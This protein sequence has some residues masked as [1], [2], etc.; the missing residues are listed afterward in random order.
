MQSKFQKISKFFLLLTFLTIIFLPA[1][2]FAQNKNSNT[3]ANSNT[4]SVNTNSSTTNAPTISGITTLPP[5]RFADT[6]ALVRGIINWL[7]GLTAAF[8][9]F[10][11]AY[12]GIMYMTAGG[13]VAKA[14]A[15]RKNLIWAI[16]GIIIIVLSFA[17]INWV[18]AIF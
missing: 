15:A 18:I 17:I 7:L 5:S 8:A 4:N 13:D 6:A 9:V 12:S 10:A 1:K 11:V 14:E 2:I 16:T 3:N